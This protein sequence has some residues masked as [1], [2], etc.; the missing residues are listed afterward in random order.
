MVNFF[1]NFIGEIRQFPPPNKSGNMWNNILFIIFIFP[2]FCELFHT[3]NKNKIKS[4]T[5]VLLRVFFFGKNQNNSPR[6]PIV[7][8]GFKANRT[9][10]S[11]ILNSCHLQ[12][13]TLRISHKPRQQLV[14]TVRKKSRTCRCFHADSEYPEPAVLLFWERVRKDPAVIG[15]RLTRTR[16]NT[17]KEGTLFFFSTQQGRYGKTLAKL[18]LCVRRSRLCERKSDGPDS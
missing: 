12:S 6:K 15:H 1:C 7:L 10:G 5:I 13:N 16:R 4:S 9:G 17:V 3:K 11:Y 14:W 18:V 8:W 2:H